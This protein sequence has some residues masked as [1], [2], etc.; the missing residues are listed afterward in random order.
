MDAA[1]KLPQIHRHCCWHPIEEMLPRCE[2]VVD[3]RRSWLIFA[4]G[5]KG[6]GLVR[7][8]LGVFRYSCGPKQVRVALRG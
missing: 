4:D 1:R 7:L 5:K 2:N 3:Q 8:C 6:A